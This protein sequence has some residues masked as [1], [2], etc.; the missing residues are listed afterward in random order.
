MNNSYDKLI[1]FYANNIIR[2]TPEIKNK[3]EYQIQGQ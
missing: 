2:Q 1:G 3:Q